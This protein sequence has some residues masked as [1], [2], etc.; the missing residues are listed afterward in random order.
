MSQDEFDFGDPSLAAKFWTFHKENPHV[1]QL[2]KRFTF[3]AIRAGRSHYS[4]QSIFERMRWYTDIETN[5]PD[6]KLNNNHRP[7]Y[8]RLFM[9]DHPEHKDFFRLRTA[10]ADE[11]FNV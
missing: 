11:E 1:Y 8:S 2:V 3:Q 9:D 5:D 4:I 10:K 6:F 7:F